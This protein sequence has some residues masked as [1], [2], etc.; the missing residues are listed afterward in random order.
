MITVRQATIADLD[1]LVPLFDRYRQFYGSATDQEAARAFI[2]A[3]FNHAESVFFLA[4]ENGNPVGFTQLYPLFSSL[5]LGRIFLLNDLFVY[6]CGRKQGV[7]TQLLAAATEF[8]KS[9]G[10]TGL[11]LSTARTNSTAQSVYE[12]AGWVRDNQFLVYDLT[13]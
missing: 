12:A 10:A 5:S 8:A 7:G 11:T 4:L 13:F 2:V 9:V 3:R 6:E 1:A